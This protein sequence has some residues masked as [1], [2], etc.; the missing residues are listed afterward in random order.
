MEANEYLPPGTPGHGYSGYVNT[1]ISDPSSF[2]QSS[3][4]Q[5]LASR[6]I[7]V[8]GGDVARDVNAPDPNRDQATG[9]FGMA[10]HADRNGKRAGSNTYLKSTLA[11]PA[12]YKLKIQLETLVSKVLF[13]RDGKHKKPRAIGVEVLKGAHLYEVCTSDD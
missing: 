2:K 11:D 10:S 4:V 13:E 5:R 7:E 1:T 6:L 8:T 3:D 12:K 9:V